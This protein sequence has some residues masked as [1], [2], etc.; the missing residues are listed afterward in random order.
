MRDQAV[1]L[2]V[3]LVG[4]FGIIGVVMTALTRAVRKDTTA[5]DK[6][7]TWQTYPSWEEYANRY[8]AEREG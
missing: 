6:Q 5:Y 8:D 4:L 3:W 7:F 1:Y 2:G